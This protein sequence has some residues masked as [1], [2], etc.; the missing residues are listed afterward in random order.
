MNRD[1]RTPLILTQFAQRALLAAQKRLPPVVSRPDAWL[2][3]AVVVVNA[4][5]VVALA[6][7][8]AGLALTFLVGASK[9]TA[10]ATAPKVES[11][12][13]AGANAPSTDYTAIAAWHLFGRLEAGRPVEAAPAP[14]PVTPLNL[15]L[16]GVFFIERSADRALALIAEGSGP[17]RGYRIGESLPGG[18]RLERVQR[19]HVVVSRN[20]RQEMLNLPKIGDP[21]STPA[22]APAPEPESAPASS[23]EPRVI[24]ASVMAQRLRTEMAT[25]PQALEDIAFAS[26]YMQSGQ[27]V[28]FRLRPG[29]DQQLLR[30]L[31]LN[32]GDVITEINGSRLNNPMQGFSI[33][34]EVMSA[35]QVSLRVLR[36][37]AEIPLT[38]SLS[39]PLPR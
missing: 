35:D 30:Q 15:R 28:G 26:P 4:G 29:R 24:D 6:Y 14:L 18:A 17:E 31:G 25:R 10:V 34:Q 23:V 19:D 8:L 11:S 38:F 32:S 1:P 21:N 33:L 20:G 36:S 39:S 13:S 3:I 27:F 16:V 37:G 22:P 7:A 12:A 9:P 2:R 5:L